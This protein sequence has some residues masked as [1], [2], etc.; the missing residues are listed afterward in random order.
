MHETVQKIAVFRALKLGDLVCATPALR[1]LRERFP[2]AHITL[3]GLPW[4]RDLAKRLSADEARW[5][6][7]FVA[8]PGHPGLPE[9]PCSRASFEAWAAQMRERRFDLAVQMHGSGRISNGVVQAIGAR[10]TVGFH[11]DTP[12]GEIGDA[13]RRLWPYPEDLHEIHRNLCLVKHLGGH[14]QDDQVAFPLLDEDFDELAR[15]ADLDE[16]PVG[17]FICL[18][19]GAR[20]ASKRW[21]P[22]RFAAVGDALACNGWRIVL[23]GDASEHALA[24]QVQEHMHAPALNAARA[25]SVGALAALLSRSRLLVSNDTG[26]SHIASALQ[27]PSV[28][29]F[30]ATDPRRWAPLDG[31]RH[32]CVMRAEDRPGGGVSPEEVVEAAWPL[33]A[34]PAPLRATGA[35]KRPRARAARTE[36]QP[37][38]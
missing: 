33:L 34:L 1:A 12:A 15:H 30:F 31:L 8:F 6:D 14:A 38:R 21:D 18:H 5:V 24:A 32:R 35:V 28:V 9:Q 29:I 25:L 36:A 26:V 19:P 22:R 13:G 10:R 37:V 23:T 2:G 7:D 4:A 3:I 16:L 11:A 20:M 17:G 27:L